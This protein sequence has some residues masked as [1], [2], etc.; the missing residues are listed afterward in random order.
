MPDT[1]LTQFGQPGKFR[2]LP[3]FDCEPPEADISMLF[4][5]WTAGEAYRAITGR[6]LPYRDGQVRFFVVSHLIEA[7][8]SVIRTPT[9]RNP[10]HVSVMAPSGSADRA[11]WE[12]PDRVT[13]RELAL[14]GEQGVEQA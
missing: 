10:H 5:R 13:L 11:W 4:D 6:P 8:Y 14:A 1:V 7:G 2:E 3:R 12:R 9:H